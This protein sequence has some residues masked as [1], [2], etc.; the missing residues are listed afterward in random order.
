VLKERGKKTV[1]P[2]QLSQ[3]EGMPYSLPL[4]GEGKKGINAST[5]V[6][7]NQSKKKRKQLLHFYKERRQ[8]MLRGR[9]V[10]NLFKLNY[11]LKGNKEKK[12]KGGKADSKLWRQQEKGKR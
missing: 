2:L 11:L 4:K 8:M 1:V 10:F 3:K 12:K 9:P 6:P 7:P 5:T